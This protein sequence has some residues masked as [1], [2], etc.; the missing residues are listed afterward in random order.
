MISVLYVDDDL[1]LLELGKL[2]LERT[3]EF[4]VELRDSA[5]E[6]VELL[7]NTSFDII[8]S[9]YEMPV[10]NGLEFLKEVRSTLGEIPFILFSGR[11]R[12]EVVIQALND[13]ADYYL[14]K[15][16]DPKPQFVELTHKMKLAVQRRNIGIELKESEQRYREV[17]ETQSEFICRFTPGG[18]TVFVNEAYCN[19]FGIKR[20]E[21]IGQRFI[22]DI[23]ED[24]REKVHTHFALLTQDS[25]VGEIEHRIRMPDGSLRW[26]RWRDL[27]IFN[28]KG[29][30]IEYQS[31]GRDI[32][33][34]KQVEEELKQSESLYRAVFENTGAATIIIGP[35]TII[36][37]ANSGWEKLTGVPIAEQ[38]KKLSWTKFIDEDDVKRMVEYHHIR[39]KDPSLA[40]TVYECRAHNEADGSVHTCIV[41]VDIIPGSD[42]SV[43]SLVDI[44]NQ[45]QYA[46]EVQ[47]AN[48]ELTTT[49]EE[50]QAQFE[51]LKRNQ[52]I[53]RESEEK[54]RRILENMQDVY[55]QTDKEGKI[56][57]TSPSATS[58][59]GYPD[60]TEYYGKKV[61]DALYYNPEDRKEFLTEIEKTGKVENY[62][63]TLRKGDGT[64]ITVLT[65]S[66][67]YYDNTGNYLGIEGLFRDIS[68]RKQMEIRLNESENLHRAVF[69]NTG[70]IILVVESD[71]TIVYANKKFV[72]LSGYSKEKL[73]GKMCWTDFIMPEDLI[74]MKEYHRLRRANP[75]SPPPVYP[76]RFVDRF[77]K[78]RY[79]INNVAMIPGTE[80]SVTSAIDITDQVIAETEYH[81]IFENIQDVF[82]RSDSEGKII[83]ISPSAT[84]VLGY[85]SLAELIGKKIAETL[86][87]KPQDR[88]TFLRDMKENGSVTNYEVQLKKKDGTPIT[89][90]TSSHYYYDH[91]GNYVGIEGIFRDITERKQI[92]ILYKT[93]FDKTGIPM[94]ILNE[95][96]VIS[97]MN[98]EFEQAFGYTRSEIIGQLQWP[99]LIADDDRGRM[100]EYYA[101]QKKNLSALLENNAFTYVL[102]NGETQVGA[103]LITSI[104]GTRKS[105]ISIE[106]I[107]DLEETRTK[108]KSTEEEMNQLLNQLP[109]YVIIYEGET[110]VYVNDEGARLMG[111]T[112]EEIIGTSVLSFA[113]PEYHD[114]PIQ[115]IGFRYQGISI[116]PYLIEV[117][118]PSG[119]R[120]W[121]E[122]RSAS[123]AGRLK[124]ATLA[125]LT[126]VTEQKKAEIALK[127]SELQYRTII[128]NM[129]DLVYRADISGN[130]IMISPA[131]VRL[132]GFSSADEMIG[133]NISHMFYSNP[134][135]RE[136]LLELLQKDE[137]VTNFPT[138]LVDK[139][140]NIHQVTVSSQFYRDIHGNIIGIEGILHDVTEIKKAEEAVLLANRKL[141]LLTKITRHDIDNQLVALLGYLTI[142]DESLMGSPEHEF[143]EKA[144]S[145]AERIS[146]IIQFTKQYEEI[147]V[148]SPIWQ[149][150]RK[151]TC[152]ASEQVHLGSVIIK[153]DISED[154]EVFADP[155]LVKIIYNLIENAVRYGET[156]T[157]IRFYEEEA[158]NMV[159]IC[160][161][162][163]VGVIPEE[164][165]RIF[166]RGY[167]RNTGLGLALCR[168]ILTITDIS[169]IETGEFGRGARFEISIPST[170]WRKIPRD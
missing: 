135:E 97:D 15:G 126:D 134:G 29:T 88:E 128:E 170:G 34:R 55:Y 36:L 71:N 130:L 81:T 86:Y 33:D 59:L 119:E 72:Q 11:G 43:A 140:G 60:N 61:A 24:D 132:A 167:G 62:E 124:D 102:K 42:N 162:D 91:Q 125:V 165:E 160:E 104:P 9:D 53:I 51:E 31:L 96:L 127:E 25:P 50:L 19:Y 12:E 28:E 158:S 47:A 98:A 68:E 46:E 153:N 83:L 136:N 64:P 85:E 159:L 106:N 156:I 108:L 22:P 49:Q 138:S 87:L 144:V 69:D 44:T 30:L 168:D 21:I 38:E 155:L 133:C 1:T 92:E 150:I 39:R 23:P 117:T 3:G 32:T 116:K 145:I 146:S 131:G 139:H 40:P 94:L 48:E 100:I 161:D 20:E 5:V 115:N 35:T 164:K 77:G 154:I 37:R 112:P 143:A 137:K 18:I 67:R 26:H 107:A 14:Q 163:G 99:A 13:G 75:T 105:L 95:D 113:T 151:I 76:F 114:L 84:T 101:L 27:A 109:D 2:F 141:N 103:I 110:I 63:A 142:L 45:K 79:C 166:E 90:L 52:E 65:S 70:T 10:M 89:V 169:I 6:A 93:I 111:K 120:R 80:R 8:L 129:Q 78:M 17:V 66:H 122:V 148:K 58:V 152:D 149:N 7:K 54:Y 147:G 121:L 41:H 157:T 4:Q 16:G 118:I 57:L 82:Y 73:E 56:I 74:K 123:L